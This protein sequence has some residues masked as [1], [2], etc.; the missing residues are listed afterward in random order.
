MFRDQEKFDIGDIG[1]VEF[2]YLGTSRVVIRSIQEHRNIFRKKR[3]TYIV[4][5]AD[6]L[7]KGDYMKVYHED[8]IY[9][10]YCL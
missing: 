7:G 10:N 5:N 1:F 6:N 4:E 9:D 2:Q 8:F 3:Y